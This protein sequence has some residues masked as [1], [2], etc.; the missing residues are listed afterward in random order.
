MYS[1]LTLRSPLYLGG[2]SNYTAL[3][4]IGINVG[5]SGCVERL[6]IN[7]V[8]QD[9][10]QEPRGFAVAGIDVGKL[11]KI[12]GMRDN[13]LFLADFLFFGFEFPLFSFTFCV[14]KYRN[15]IFSSIFFMDSYSHA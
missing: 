13:F 11:D 5:F 15:S 10:R 6:V 1:K 2:H 12:T 8:D 14:Q 9:M 3:D 4:D 7:N